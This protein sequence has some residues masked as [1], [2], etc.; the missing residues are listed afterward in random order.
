VKLCKRPGCEQLDPQVIRLIVAALSSVEEKYITVTVLGADDKDSCC[1][2]YEIII[3]A[4][5]GTYDVATA[6]NKVS[7]ALQG[8]PEFE[9]EPQVASNSQALTASISLTV[10]G[11]LLM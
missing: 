5:K 8:N 10:A 9:V 2:R 4:E 7:N 1:Y 6:T 11:L 3:A